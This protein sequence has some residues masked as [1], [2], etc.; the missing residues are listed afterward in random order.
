MIRKKMGKEPS[1]EQES[2]PFENLNSR[3]NQ[4]KSSPF[5]V[6]YATANPKKSE[7]A[8]SINQ[9]AN[10]FL[11]N[12][13]ASFCAFLNNSSQHIF[14]KENQTGPSRNVADKQVRSRESSHSRTLTPQ[15]Q[16]TDT[17]ISLC[18]S[19]QFS[20]NK[21]HLRRKSLTHQT[22][23]LLQTKSEI[24]QFLPLQKSKPLTRESQLPKK[25]LP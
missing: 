11:N 8:S 23:A 17:N 13:N 3:I 4:R 14:N 22:K 9:K 6:H 10:S 12:S 15:F 20:L 24:S 25:P 2:V 16:A 21:N 7:V 1:A 5:K 18:S 19:S